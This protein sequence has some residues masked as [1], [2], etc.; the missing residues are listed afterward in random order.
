MKLTRRELAGM[1]AAIVPAA[2]R[3]DEPD[4]PEQLYKSAAEDA[5]KAAGEI[6]NF[7]TPIETEPAFTFRAQ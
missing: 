7:K 5:R 6:R 3:G 2:V 1:A 4:S